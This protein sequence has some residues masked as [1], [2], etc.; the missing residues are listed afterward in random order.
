[1]SAPLPT[2]ILERVEIDHTVLDLF[3][4]DEE[5]RLPI[6]RPTLTFALDVYSRYPVGCY[7]GFENPSYRAVQNCLFHA[8]LPKQD[9]RELYGTKN[10]WLAYG[11][12]EMLV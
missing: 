7:V 4:V 10:E 11:L 12:P 1:S 3:L 5:D 8:I 6:G 9:T 2:R